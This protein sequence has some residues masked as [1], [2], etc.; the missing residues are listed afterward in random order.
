MKGAMISIAGGSGV[1]SGMSS[2]SQ[3]FT[4]VPALLSCATIGWQVSVWFST[5]IFQ[6]HLCM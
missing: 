2:S 5:S 4:A 3:S 1:P 6:L